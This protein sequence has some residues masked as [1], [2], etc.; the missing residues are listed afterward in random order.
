MRSSEFSGTLRYFPVTMGVAINL[1]T[2]CSF[3]SPG[4]V[5]CKAELLRDHGH[6][7]PQQPL[8]VLLHS[9]SRPAG[10]VPPEPSHPATG[11]VGQIV[12]G[13]HGAGVIHTNDDKRRDIS[14]GNQLGSGV[15]QTP[16]DTLLTIGDNAWSSGSHNAANHAWRMAHG[17]CF[18]PTWCAS[19]HSN[20][21]CASLT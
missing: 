15:A 20:L 17:A 3:T 9:A 13:A 2:P 5:R 6:D 14:R 4:W 8:H 19:Q 18:T 7:F 11:G 12:E 21:F 1:M 16:R 10:G